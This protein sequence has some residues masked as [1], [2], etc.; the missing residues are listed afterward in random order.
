MDGKPAD[1]YLEPVSISMYF[2]PEIPTDYPLFAHENE[3][4]HKFCKLEKTSKVWIY[5]DEFDQVYFAERENRPGSS[6]PS[7]SGSKRVV[8]NSQDPTL[9]VDQAINNDDY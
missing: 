2:E 8:M 7:I 6:D 3:Y 1:I 5:V 9:L 4:L